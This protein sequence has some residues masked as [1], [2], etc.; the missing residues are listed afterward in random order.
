MCARIVRD[1]E[2][3]ADWCVRSRDA[4][5]SIRLSSY[6]SNRDSSVQFTL[7]SGTREQRVNVSCDC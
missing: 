1:F 2:R 6:S 4:L 7:A 5:L 3:L